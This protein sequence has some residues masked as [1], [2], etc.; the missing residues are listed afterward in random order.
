MAQEKNPF[1]RPKFLNMDPM[2]STGGGG[3]FE[4]DSDQQIYG[5][6]Y[7]PIPDNPNAGFGYPT[8]GGRG[9]TVMWLIIAAV[10]IYLLTRKGKK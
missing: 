1:N 4:I 8:M 9:N 3:M 2:G 10:V 5:D 7:A 6:Q